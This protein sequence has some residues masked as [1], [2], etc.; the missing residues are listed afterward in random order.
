M[1]NALGNMKKRGKVNTFKFNDSACSF[2]E[3]AYFL[4]IATYFLNDASRS[5]SLN[6]KVVKPLT[7]HR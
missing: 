3:L 6:S 7:K 4:T 1:K 5:Q 2:L